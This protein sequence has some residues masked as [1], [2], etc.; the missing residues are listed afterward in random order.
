[1]NET[2][3]VFDIGACEGEDSIR[4][5]RLFPAARI[6]AFEPR[7]DN[8]ERARSNFK[9]YGV[10]SVTLEQIALSDQDGTA[11]FYYSEGQPDNV[12][13][14]ENWNFGNKSSSLLA[15]GEEIKKHHS[16][17][18]FREP[19]KVQTNTLASYTAEKKIS[20]IDLVHLDVQG[21]ELMV[22]KGA[23][24]K[25]KDIRLIWLEVESVALYRKQALKG[26]IA[27]FMKKQ[28][29]VNVIDTAGE[30]SG[31]RLYVNKKYFSFW[32]I[33]RLRLREL[34]KKL[35]PGLQKQ[36]SPHFIVGICF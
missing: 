30:V 25:I 7:T 14:G 32:Q 19:V 29:F 16:W 3:V 36:G 1:V 21:A 15:P 17:L 6:Y 10:S 23:G 22:L 4:Y 12:P 20:Q 26:E 31:D 8:C 35:T 34:L 28:G 27:A 2:K 33:T 13:S 5:A 24:E 18:K 9:K 11:D